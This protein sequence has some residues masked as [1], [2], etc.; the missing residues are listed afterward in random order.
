MLLDNIFVINL[1]R[2]TERLKNIT[3]NFQEHGINFER[4]GATEG[5]KLSYNEIENEASL[6]CRTLICNYGM[7][8]CAI[9]HKN[10]WKRLVSDP[11]ADYYIIMEDD[12]IID[13]DFKNIIQEIDSIKD[14]LNIDI[15]SLYCGPFKNVQCNHITQVY[16]LSNGIIIG[17]PIFPLSLIGY[18]ISKQ[19]AKKLLSSIIKINAGIDT[20]MALKNMFDDLNYY[21]LSK[22]IIKH[23][24]DML[25][26]IEVNHDNKSILLNILLALGLNDIYWLLNSVILTLFLKYTINLYLIILIFLLIL[27]VLIFKNKF[28]Y[29][30]IILEII[31]LNL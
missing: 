30:F 4:Y 21:S 24:W 17:K 27:N 7:V 10:L 22:N 23:N 6:L 16:T 28:L 8:G 5:I 31:L 14:K 13:N 25:S 19:G 3:K 9:S 26:E 15:L 20:E 1:D 11:N 29:I 18:I 2:S 12:A